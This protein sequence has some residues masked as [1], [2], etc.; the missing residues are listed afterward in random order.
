MPLDGIV[1]RRKQ[2]EFQ[3][4]EP[5][6]Q[7]LRLVLLIFGDKTLLLLVMKTLKLTN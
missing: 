7:G 1:L 4:L 6:R 2:T 5:D 3:A